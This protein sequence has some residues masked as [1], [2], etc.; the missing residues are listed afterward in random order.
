[1]SGVSGVVSLSVIISLMGKDTTPD[2]LLIEDGD[3]VICLSCHRAH[4]S[5][6]PDMLRWDYN[7]MIVDRTGPAAG[8]GCF[9][10]HTDKDGE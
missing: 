9:K 10:C 4:A 7:L 5:D 8:T 2:I 1:M 3:M 6:Q